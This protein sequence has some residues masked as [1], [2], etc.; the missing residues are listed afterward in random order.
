MTFFIISLTHDEILM[1][2]KKL[3]SELPSLDCINM[4]WYRTHI[5]QPFYCKCSY[6][7]NLSDVLQLYCQTMSYRGQK[8]LI[9][10][11]LGNGTFHYVTFHCEDDGDHLAY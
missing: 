7:M 9:F 4:C 11:Q 8:W 6:V 3:S 1:K 2:V 5:T 10:S